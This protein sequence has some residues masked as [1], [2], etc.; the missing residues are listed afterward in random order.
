MIDPLLDP[1]VKSLT[2][3]Y[4]G[5]AQAYNAY[6]APVL[7]GPA[8]LLLDNL[9]AKGVRRVVDVGTGV[10]TF[11][12]ALKETFPA[13]TV[14][15]AD[16]SD[17]MLSLAPDDSPLVVTDA[18]HLGIASNSVDVVTFVF[19]LF[20]LP[21]PL[22]GLKE[23]HRV[24]R[25]EGR[26]ATVTWGDEFD[27]TATKLWNVELDAFGADP[28]TVENHLAQHD[29]VDTSAKMKSLMR[30]A[31]FSSVRATTRRC[32]HLIDMDHL[33]RLRTGMGRHRTRFNSLS[34]GR[35]E[36]FLASIQGKLAG[37]KRD[38][39]VCQGTFVY[40]VGTVA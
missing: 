9:E 30:N 35:Q 19:M 26:V 24:L 12:P 32:E 6:W 14:F 34:R 10:G 39:F 17:G 20:H 1:R 16:R 5:E 18:S 38:D 7:R 2:E 36:E 40:C 13:A 4:T 28:L 31:G 23:A 25:R 21:D 15:G 29:L 27:S 22:Q 11:L 33:I 37:L 8:R 3:R